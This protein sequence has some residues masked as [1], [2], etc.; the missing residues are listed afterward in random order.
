MN[1]TLSR[2]TT[3]A[4]PFGRYKWKRIPFSIAP[5]GEIFQICLDQAIEGLDGIRTVADDILVI[6]NG[7]SMSEAIADHDRK[8]TSLLTSCRERKIKNQAKIELQK[9]SIPY[10][11]HV[12]RC[13]RCQKVSKLFHQ[14]SLLLQK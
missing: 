12:L 4:T 13:Q 7:D 9:A 3:F 6:G 8:L 10:I 2:L 11:G 5:A 14:R 1:K